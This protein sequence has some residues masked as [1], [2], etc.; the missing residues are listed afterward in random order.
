M[1][2]V[3]VLEFISPPQ[4]VLSSVV[5][6]AVVINFT[7]SSFFLEPFGQFSQTWHKALL[8]KGD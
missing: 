3:D 8:C 4:I 6:V 7:F 2:Y 1:I 5:L